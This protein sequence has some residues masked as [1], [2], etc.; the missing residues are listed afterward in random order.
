MVKHE[1]SCEI[2]FCKLLIVSYLNRISKKYK[3]IL[4]RDSTIFK[5]IKIILKVSNFSTLTHLL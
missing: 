2:K 4:T 5:A 3:L 1:K